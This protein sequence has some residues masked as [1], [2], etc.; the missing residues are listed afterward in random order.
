MP[1]NYGTISISKQSSLVIETGAMLENNNYI[2][3]HGT[4]NVQGS[5]AG[6]NADLFTGGVL[7]PNTVPHCTEGVL[8]ESIDILGQDTVLINSENEYAY[9][10]SPDDVWINW[11]AWSIVSGDSLAEIGKYT[12]ILKTKILKAKLLFA[13]PLLMIQVYTRKRL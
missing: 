13:L 8:V 10:L 1:K 3:I 6:Y 5:Y 12:G 11:A 9:V 4:L 2:Q 7:I